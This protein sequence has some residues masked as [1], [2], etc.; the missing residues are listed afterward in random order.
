M[1]GGKKMKKTVSLIIVA[2]ISISYL[3]TNVF[4]YDTQIEGDVI[5][6]D[7]AADRDDDGVSSAATGLE[8]IDVDGSATGTS[9]IGSGHRVILLGESR[10]TGQRGSGR[11]RRGA[12]DIIS[13]ED[14]EDLHGNRRGRI[15]HLESSGEFFGLASGEYTY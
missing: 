6:S 14:V 4:A 12:G 13:S 11:D 15:P 9:T 10:V 1:K 3:C 2:I 8:G 5:V 7:A